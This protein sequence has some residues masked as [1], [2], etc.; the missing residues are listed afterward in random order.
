VN[1]IKANAGALRVHWNLISR[2]RVGLMNGKKLLVAL[3]QL[4]FKVFFGM[5]FWVAD[6]A[7]LNR[8][9]KE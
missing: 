1:Q 5:T 6:L 3:F 2:Q 4:W 8:Q 7:S 9:F